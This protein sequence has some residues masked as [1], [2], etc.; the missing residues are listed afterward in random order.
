MRTRWD[1]SE[2]KSVSWNPFGRSGLGAVFTQVVS[3]SV[4]KSN[5]GHCI[6]INSKSILIRHFYRYF[7]FSLF[8]FLVCF[9]WMMTTCQEVPPIQVCTATC[10]LK[11][12][13]HQP[14]SK[15]PSIPIKSRK[16]N[17]VNSKLHIT[18]DMF[19]FPDLPL[20]S[21]GQRQTDDCGK[22]LSAFLSVFCSWHSCKYNMHV[23]LELLLMIVEWMPIGFM[24]VWYQLTKMLS[25]PHKPCKTS[26][27]CQEALMMTW[28]LWPVICHSPQPQQMPYTSL[29]ALETSSLASHSCLP[30]VNWLAFFFLSF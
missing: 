30:P 25:H 8:H 27:D 11:G 9:P 16:K 19:Y 21:D 26:V 1:K 13:L 17:I 14:H 6:A 15:H 20:S 7:P 12:S 29:R 23:Q 22:W 28:C 4:S 2:L 24:I 5:K 3:K 18:N 10:Q